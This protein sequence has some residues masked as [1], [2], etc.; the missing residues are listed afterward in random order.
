MHSGSSTTGLL[1]QDLCAGPCQEDHTE[2][3]PHTPFHSGKQD[4]IL[5]SFYSTIEL[6]DESGEDK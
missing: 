4:N 3:V 2:S 1:G 5:S 6:E